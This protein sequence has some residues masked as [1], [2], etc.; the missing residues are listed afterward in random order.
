LCGG[1]D[2]L[3]SASFRAALQAFFAANIQAYE[4]PKVCALIASLRAGAGIGVG[5]MFSQSD[6][7]FGL[8][9]L[10]KTSEAYS[11][12]TWPHW[13]PRDPTTTRSITTRYTPR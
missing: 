12:N 4:E 10:R 5:S 11:K 2:Y 13:F 7:D 9:R 3:T 6:A 8:A 1:Q